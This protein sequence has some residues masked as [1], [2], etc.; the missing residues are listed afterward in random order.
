MKRLLSSDFSGFASYLLNSEL[1]FFLSNGAGF[2]EA[3]PEIFQGREVSWN[4]GTLIN[5]SFKKHKK[6]GP[7]GKIWEFFLLGNLKITP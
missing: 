3:Q 2:T 6:N 4:Q 1:M 5:L 7:A